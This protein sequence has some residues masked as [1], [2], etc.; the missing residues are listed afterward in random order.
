MD[1][2]YTTPVEKLEATDFKNLVRLALEEDKPEQDITSEAIF[3]KDQ[4]ATATLIAKE[5]G[6]LAGSIVLE[7]LKDQTGHLF[8]YETFKKD[9][10]EFK[11]KDKI[12]QIKGNL[13]VI[14]RIE[15]ILL[16]FLQY[17]SGIATEANKISSKY[18]NRLMI[19]DTRKTLPAYRKLAKYA[20]YIGG[21]CNHRQNLSD[22][23]L[24]KDNHVAMS[25]SIE[26]AVK[27]IRTKFPN[28]K[29]ELEIDGLFQLD[30]A[31]NSS[32]DIIMLDNFTVEDTK[33]AVEKIKNKQSG[34]S[35]NC[36]KKQRKLYLLYQA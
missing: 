28:K 4:M 21:A 1:R 35:K 12:L 15:R 23:G 36:G 22:M 30:D 27:K 17:L 2:F 3:E 10:E 14:L 24:I 25:G 34:D 31:I 7:E 18:K 6:I 9:G 29:I 5:S 13:I 20:V 19:F 8:S 32:P 26:E 16:N 33:I 11:P